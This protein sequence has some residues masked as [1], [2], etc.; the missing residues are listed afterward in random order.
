MAE[1]AREDA[2]GRV[3]GLWTGIAAAVRQDLCPAEDGLAIARNT[4]AAATGLRVDAAE[5]AWWTR[6]GQARNGT[7]G[8]AAWSLNIWL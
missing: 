4:V 7:G 5:G 3:R 1:A 2:A 8:K 6:E